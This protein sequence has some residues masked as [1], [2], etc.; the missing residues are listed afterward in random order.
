MPNLE[1]TS[2]SA[3]L[4]PPLHFTPESTQCCFCIDQFSYLLR[5]WQYFDQQLLTFTVKLGSQ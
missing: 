1:K 2:K 3:S 5:S 4:N